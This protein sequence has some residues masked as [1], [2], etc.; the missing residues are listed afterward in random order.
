MIPQN[1]ADLVLMKHVLLSVLET[2][3]FL[4]TVKVFFSSGFFLLIETS[5]QQHLFEMYFI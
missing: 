3:I 2:V 4:D 1:S 5:Q